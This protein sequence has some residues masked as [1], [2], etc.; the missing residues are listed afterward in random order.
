M[1]F[2][3]QDFYSNFTASL[4]SGD[5]NL[6]SDILA[7][8]ISDFIVFET[9]KIIDSLQ[10]ADIQITDKVTDEEIV[11]A[12]MK[13]LNDSP[14]LKKT[15]AFIIADGNNLINTGKSNDKAKQVQIVNDISTGLTKANNSIIS[16]SKKFKDETMNQIVSKAGSRKEYKRIIFKKDK[17]N[18]KI[19]LYWLVAG[20]S[21]VAIVGLIYWRQKKAVQ[22]SLPN[23]IMGNGGVADFS[24]PNFHT[25]APAPGQPPAILPE[26]PAVAPAPIQAP[27]PAPIINTNPIPTHN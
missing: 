14:K 22:Q 16:D 11:D 25:Q 15:L 7:N 12:V 5:L 3:N 6:T 27:A 21:L 4:K 24:Q 8:E 19:G 20:V 13:G 9:G 23:M 10:K 26:I 18:G 1:Q 17:R 2:T